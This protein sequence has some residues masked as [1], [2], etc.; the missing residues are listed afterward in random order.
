MIKS[1]KHRK[2]INM[3]TIKFFNNERK[4]LASVE[5]KDSVSITEALNKLTKNEL[6]TIKQAYILFREKRLD[7]EV[8]TL[9]EL[10]NIEDF[11]VWLLD[12]V[13]ALYNFYDIDEIDDRENITIR[14]LYEMAKKSNALDIPITYNSFYD[15][16]NIFL[17]KPDVTI[18]NMEVNL[19]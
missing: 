1:L 15:D 13:D 12:D 5:I 3:V 7:F 6:Q 2:E 18:T 17:K 9:D 4:I 10:K 16:E 11:A 8:P 19:F 14:Q